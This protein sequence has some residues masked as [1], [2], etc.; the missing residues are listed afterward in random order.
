MIYCLCT[1]F[2]ENEWCY[3]D[4]AEYIMQYENIMFVDP[5]V[6]YLF[7]HNKLNISEIE[8]F[9]HTFTLHFLFKLLPSDAPIPFNLEL[10]SLRRSPDFDV[11]SC[12]TIMAE[13]IDSTIRYLF[14]SKTLDLFVDLLYR[15]SSEWFMVITE[16]TDC[17]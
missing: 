7:P 6:G 9:I 12:L 2:I 8:T 13:I 1:D 16:D 5:S 17:Q 4:L 11:D 3:D 10:F 14:R 15:L